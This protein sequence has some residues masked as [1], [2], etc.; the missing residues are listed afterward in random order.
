MS[1]LRNPFAPFDTALASAF[2]QNLAM[3]LAEDIGTG[4]W[5]AK[6]LSE[7]SHVQARLTVR[8]EAVLCGAPW[9]E[10]AMT[11]VDPRLLIDWHYAEGDLVPA[12]K[13]VCSIAGPARSLLTAERT[14]MNFL[15]LLSGVATATRSYVT[16]V[17]GTRATIL[18]TRKTLPGLRVAQKYAVRVGGGQ[19]QRL[20]LYDGIL[21]KENHIAAAG[22]IAAALQAANALHA[23]VPIQIE[24][25]T[26]E[27]L[28]QAL[29][30][31]ANA[32][33]L[34]NFTLAQM[35]EAVTITSGRAVLEASG[36]IRRDTVRA[37]AETGVDRISIGSLTKDIRAVDYSLR[38][39][40]SAL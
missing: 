27:Q 14:A 12:D 5:T 23:G 39:V 30:A 33:L 20:A 16:L 38:V 36:G 35:R 11:A 6:L 22:G 10:G 24:V 37:I 3:A 18:D 7:H 9:F 40:S 31:G 19:N 32:V 26:I 21:I 13:V 8:E 25:E 1:T 17:A 34:D 4:D 15:Q 2:E 29:A 28:G